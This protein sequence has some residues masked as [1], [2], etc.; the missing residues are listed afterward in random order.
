VSQ[1]NVEVVRAAWEAW[2][3]R[4][5]TALFAL[6]DPDIVWDQT[7][8][9]TSGLTGEYHGHEGVKT[10]FRAWM[11]PFESFHAHAEE[12]I[13]VG[14]A[15]VVRARQGGRGK[16][17]GVEVE[18]PSYWQVYRVQDGLVARIVVYDNEADA[19]NAARVKE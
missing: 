18:M 13:E 8:Q 15:V 6:Y 3:R 11:G 7:H 16:R 5:M 19:L 10:F 12:F 2:D 1:E 4:D 9:Q 14:E 17:S